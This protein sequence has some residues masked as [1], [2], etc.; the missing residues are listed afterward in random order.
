MAIVTGVGPGIGRATARALAADGYDLVL[1]AR[2]PEPLAEV[3]SELEDLGVNALAVPTDVGDLTQCAA[4]VDAAVAR[5]ERIDVLVNSAAKGAPNHTILNADLDEWQL[6]W[7]INVLGPI[8]LARRAMPYLFKSDN[9]SVIM[10]STLAVRAINPGQAAYAA[11][12]AALGIAA[13]TLSKEV[14]KQGVRVNIVVPGFVP[15]PNAEAMFGRMAERRGVSI[16]EV[17]AEMAGHTALRRLPVPE[18]I[19]DAIAFLVSPRAKS[20]TGQ[21][22]DVNGGNWM[23]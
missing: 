11:T 21:T 5:F 18:D 14:G 4:L 15:G 23:S 17:Q 2:R 10:V 22:L 8:E 13:Q 6:A 3:A 20:I 16:D 9:P 7:Q 1:A 19:A 12:K